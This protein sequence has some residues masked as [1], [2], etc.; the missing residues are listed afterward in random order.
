[1]KSGERMYLSPYTCSPL[2][3]A[4]TSGSRYCSPL[5]C[6]PSCR[7]G[8]VLRP[9]WRG[10]AAPQEGTPDIPAWC[11]PDHCAETGMSA[12]P[13]L[14]PLLAGAAG[15]VSAPVL[16]RPAGALLLFTG[17]LG[18]YPR[19]TNG[20]PLWGEHHQHRP[21]AAPTR[22]EDT[23]VPTGGLVFSI[24]GKDPLVLVPVP[25]IRDCGELGRAT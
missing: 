21:P 5:R 10:A 6:L 20:R 3:I 13:S 22:A 8:R 4:S 19:L 14:A 15:S 2:P 18:V 11:F 9:C 1:M 25:L 23:P 16:T 24:P 7:H 17:F 12:L